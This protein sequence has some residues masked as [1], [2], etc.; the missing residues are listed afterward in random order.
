MLIS[1]LNLA[2]DCSFGRKQCFNLER[3]RQRFTFTITA[4]QNSEDLEFRCAQMESK[5][6]NGIKGAEQIYDLK[7]KHAFLGQF[8]DWVLYAGEM[9]FQPKFDKLSD[10]VKKGGDVRLDDVMVVIDNNSGTVCLMRPNTPKRHTQ[11]ATPTRTLFS[12]AGL[13]FNTS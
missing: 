4:H 5:F 7:S 3:S 1:K 6:L 9:W 11:S 10:E 8:K 12:P 13:V 2:K